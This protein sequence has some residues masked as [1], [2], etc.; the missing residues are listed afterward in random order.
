MS[1]TQ[2]T[3]YWDQN[4]N[5]TIENKNIEI[6]GFSFK[7]VPISLFQ[8]FY[9]SA[10]KGVNEQSFITQFQ[11][12]DSESRIVHLLC[13]QLVARKIIRKNVVDVERVF[14]GQARYIN[15]KYPT[16]YF[17]N[18]ENTK[19]FHDK[20][21]MRFPSST[22]S[23]NDNIALDDSVAVDNF[24]AARK[25]V[26]QFN[27]R[28]KIPLA[29]FKTL[30]LSV[31][32]RYE[33]GQI[34][35]YY[36]SAGGLYPNNLYFYIKPNRIEKVDGGLYSL[37]PITKQL[38]LISPHPDITKESEYFTNMETFSQ[39]AF[40]VYVTYNANINMPKYDD[41]GYMF[42]LI[43]AGII[44]ELLTNTATQ[45]QIGT[46]IIGEMNFK[47]IEHNFHLVPNEIYLQSM[48]FGLA[49]GE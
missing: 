36:P 5:W 8:H 49:K 14:K 17:L 37:N 20:Q 27:M 35:Y 23:M 46:C 43:E 9:E 16:D 48:E 40:S 6:N 1:D 42:G 33:D 25:S 44:L 39:S 29:S 13:R 38:I 24:L 10:R 12:S 28:Q 15:S 4:V 26:R 21:L 41:L 7:G 47:K 11:L 18:A 19:A 3:Y 30:V 32:S 45:L 34:R 22:R 31:S 2:L